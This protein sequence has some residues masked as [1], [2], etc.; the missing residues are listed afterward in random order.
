[1]SKNTTIKQVR[2]ELQLSN[3]DIAVLLDFKDARSYGNSPKRK[4]Y[5]DC[6]IEIYK[7]TKAKYQQD[8]TS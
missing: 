5:E 2:K 7:R 6:M 4:F 8:E 3:E 1:M